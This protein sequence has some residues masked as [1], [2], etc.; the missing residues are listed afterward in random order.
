MKEF[1]NH[2]AAKL[3]IVEVEKFVRDLSVLLVVTVTQNVHQIELVSVINASVSFYSLKILNYL[4]I[5]Y[6][7]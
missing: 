5:L 4:L 1:V 7:A 2:Y 6:V 3:M